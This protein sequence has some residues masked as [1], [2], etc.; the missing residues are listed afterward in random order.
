MRCLSENIAQRANHEDDCRGRFWSGRFK[1]TRLL[2]DAALLACSIYIDLNPIRAGIA[3]TPETSRYTSAY[4]RIHSLRPNRAKK[5]S[6]QK[7]KTG[8]R[9][10]DAWLSPIKL[11]ES[12][13]KSVRQ[14]QQ[15]RV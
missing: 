6:R 15:L 14:P 10:V 3:K 1:C 8:R 2:D 11:V 4:D 7:R 9:D 12:G 13:S 5:K